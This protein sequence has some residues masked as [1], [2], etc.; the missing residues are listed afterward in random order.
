[1]LSFGKQVYNQTEDDALINIS[2]A[3]AEINNNHYIA[4]KTTSLVLSK[5]TDKYTMGTDPTLGQI[6]YDL[7]SI[8]RFDLDNIGSV[9]PVSI[10]KLRGYTKCAGSPR[11][12]S[13]YLSND[14][15]VLELDC[16]P[17]DN[18][19]ATILYNPKCDIY[20]GAGGVNTNTMWSAFDKTSAGY[21][22]SLP[23]ENRYV[24]AV[25]ER[26]LCELFPE[27]LQFASAILQESLTNKPITFDGNLPD[28]FE[29][30]RV[31]QPGQDCDR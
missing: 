9:N 25:V 10:F 6:P 2:I 1:M 21:G 8:I 18:Y 14:S 12:Y 3:L 15:K 27:R 4:E 20:Y 22:G 26:A 19:T 7:M 5:T 28:Y 29:G 13:I 17:Q 16:L 30:E 31:R 24:N 11:F 23:I